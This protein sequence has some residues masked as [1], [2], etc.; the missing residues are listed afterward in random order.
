MQKFIKKIDAQPALDIPTLT[1]AYERR[2]ISRQRVTLDNGIEASLL[3][4]RGTVLQAGDVLCAETGQRFWH[5]ILAQGG[6]RPAME[7]FVAFRGRTPDIE[8]L[9]RHHGMSA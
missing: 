5:E 1:L 9:L 8:A 7:S 4:P 2:I 3:L 6:S